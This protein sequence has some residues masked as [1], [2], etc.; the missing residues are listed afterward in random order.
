M[1]PF[2]NETMIKPERICL[3]LTNYCDLACVFCDRQRLK[4]E[5]MALDDMSGALFQKIL[6]DI[7]A[8]YSRRDKLDTL[9][10]VGLGEPLLTRDLGK[11]LEEILTYAHVF[12]NIELTSNGTSLT[13]QKAKMLLES[14]VNCF[15]FSVNF[16]DRDVYARMMGKDRFDRVIENVRN[17]LK[18]KKEKGN[19]ASVNIQLFAE[20]EAADRDLE[21]MKSFFPEA[22]KD[23]RAVFHIQPVYNKPAVQENKA[24]LDVITSAKQR[25]PCWCLY[26]IVYIDIEGFVYP[27]TIG[28][29]C[30]RKTSS[31]NIGNIFNKSLAEIFNDDSI[32]QGRER[33]ESGQLPFAECRDC[34]IWAIMPN[35]FRYNRNKRRWDKRKAC[36]LLMK[37]KYRLRSASG[38]LPHSVQNLFR[39][40]YS[41]IF[42]SYNKKVN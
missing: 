10:L 39:K 9:V 21:K 38:R 32:V 16:T 34:N 11:R 8:V 2:K 22:A 35:I 5:G 13:E 29:D 7:G 27:C 19:R 26:S 6:K 23:P 25:H 12:R 31:L 40:I 28:N 15:T 4:H 14:A 3:E 24:V 17:F 37:L 33:A 41:L 30:Y 42:H 36:E 1:I 18:L 20:P